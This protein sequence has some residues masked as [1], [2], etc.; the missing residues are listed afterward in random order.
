MLS[1]P[2]TAP[3]MKGVKKLAAPNNKLQPCFTSSDLMSYLR[4][5]NAEPRSTIPINISVNGILS[6]V[7]M[8]ANAGG[9][10]VNKMTTMRISQT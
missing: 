8:A 7:I 1:A 4:K 6:A 9:K 3:W 2:S 5:I 10:P